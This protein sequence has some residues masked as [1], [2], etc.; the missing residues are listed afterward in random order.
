MYTSN[1]SPNETPRG[2]LRIR[3]A[4][5]I[6]E[7]RQAAPRHGYEAPRAWSS[8]V[9]FHKFNLRIFNLSLKSEQINCGC[10]FGTMSGFN[11]PGSRP[12]KTR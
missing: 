8:T 5:P 9:G 6:G 10:F 2:S 1:L 3:P 7:E 4:R 12:K 11:V